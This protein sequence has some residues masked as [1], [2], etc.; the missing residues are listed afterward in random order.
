MNKTM[1]GVL[2]L[3]CFAIVAIAAFEDTDIAKNHGKTGL[4]NLT[5]QIDSNFTAIEDGTTAIKGLTV[6]ISTS[7]YFQVVSTQ[8]Q[9]V[10]GSVTNVIDADITTP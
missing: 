8:L 6:G 7:G 1:A 3:F 10:A 5:E 9:F 2:A 4:K